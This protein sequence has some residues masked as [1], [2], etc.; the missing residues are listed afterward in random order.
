MTSEA[1]R[2][3]RRHL[4]VPDPCPFEIGQVLG[5]QDRQAG[6]PDAG[7]STMRCPRC[8]LENSDTATRCDCGHTFRPGLTEDGT[9]LSEA[10]TSPMPGDPL[11][12]QQRSYGGDQKV[13]LRFVD[14]DRPWGDWFM[15]FLRIG[16]A[17][18]V[19]G[20]VLSVPALMLS[21]VVAAA[22]HR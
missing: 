10:R 22:T 11:A 1:R 20:L 21:F 6:K 4:D 3:L 2:W 8:H 7:G 16:T 18:F 13:G 12:W 14:F 19:V 15:L 17:L 9:L 5:Q